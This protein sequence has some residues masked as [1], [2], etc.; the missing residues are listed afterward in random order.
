MRLDWS[1][2]SVWVPGP[3][4]GQVARCT[5][6]MRK[7]AQISPGSFFDSDGDSV[8]AQNE[9]SVLLVENFPDAAPDTS[10]HEPVE[11]QIRIGP[12]LVFS[13]T[14]NTILAG[15]GPLTPF[16]QVAHEISH[17]TLGTLDMYNS[18]AGSYGMTLMSG[19]SLD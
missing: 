16:Y 8:V 10:G 19:Y 3:N 13:V 9:L 6:I 5:A 15:I 11:A 12:T 7:V 2:P 17:S 4:P 1:V 18:G 14:V